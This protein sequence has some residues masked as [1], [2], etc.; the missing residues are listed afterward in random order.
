MNT[1]KVATDRSK[2]RA[3]THLAI[4]AVVVGLLL[5]GV[6]LFSSFDFV[7]FVVKLHGG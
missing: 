3:V 6:M 1:N 5:I 2:K 4:L 7:G